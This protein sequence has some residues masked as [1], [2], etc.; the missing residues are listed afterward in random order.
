M[1]REPMAGRLQDVPVTDHGLVLFVQAARWADDIE[2]G[3]SNTTG[4][5]G[6]TP[7]GFKPEGQP[8]PSKSETE[9]VNILTALAEND[10]V[11]NNETDGERRLIAPTVRHQTRQNVICRFGNNVP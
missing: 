9:P 3:T 1:V 2:S 10:S 5:R 7:I 11:V 4:D 6:I 8:Q